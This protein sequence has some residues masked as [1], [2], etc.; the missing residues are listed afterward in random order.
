MKKEYLRIKGISKKIIP[1]E[2]YK[3]IQKISCYT[4]RTE[5]LKYLVASKLKLKLLE[6]ELASGEID[7]KEALL[8]RSKLTLLKSK[9]KIFEST[10]DKHDY[11]ILL[12]LIQE[13]EHEI[14]CSTS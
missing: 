7:K 4:E 8:V 12:K 11:D 3:K 1:N 5:G 6:L 14:K 9:I 13:I 10:Y 2:Q